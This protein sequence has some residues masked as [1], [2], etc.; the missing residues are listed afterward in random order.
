MTAA[1]DTRALRGCMPV[2]RD[3]GGFAKRLLRAW[4]EDAIRREAFPYSFRE[5]AH[6]VSKRTGRQL[7]ET[8]ARSWFHGTRPGLELIAA[9]SDLLQADRDYLAFGPKP[10]PDANEIEE[11]VQAV[12]EARAGRLVQSD[13]T[14][15]VAPSRTRKRGNGT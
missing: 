7:H 13:P 11:R 3:D 1:L 14:P 6:K 4:L 15:S 10:F 5:L 12:R 8:T 2:S 9:L